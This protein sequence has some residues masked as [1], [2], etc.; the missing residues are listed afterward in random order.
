MRKTV[1][2][3]VR[4]LLVAVVVL[5]LCYV[6][7]QLLLSYQI[8]RAARLL[9]AVQRVKVGDSEASLD[10]LL[11]RY[12]DYRWDVQLGAHEDYNFVFQVNPWGFA[13]LSSGWWGDKGRLVVTSFQ[14]RIRRSVGLRQWMVDSEIAIKD[15]RVAAVQTSIIV[16]GTRMW[17]GTMSRISE[18]PRAFDRDASSVDPSPDR[19]PN[20]VETGILNL[21]SGT[22]TTWSFWTTPSSPEIQ[23]QIANDLNF[24][25]LRSFSGCETV[26]DLVPHAARF[27][28]EHPELAPNGGGW[29][30][31]RR[32]C[33]KHGAE[34][35][36]YW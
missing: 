7:G 23:H 28:N 36:R 2:I 16:E 30:E 26:C 20:L 22:G 13:T 1:F 10:S 27:F 8:R 17:L 33:A 32:A 4:L 5:L 11:K 34:D 18:K 24:G 15:H 19:T 35:D 6:S 25:C 12:G 9:E 14:Q 29:D 31:S 3:F 21:K